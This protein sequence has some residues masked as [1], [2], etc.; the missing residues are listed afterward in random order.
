[1]KKIFVFTFFLISLF[2]YATHIVGGE[3]A[4]AHVSGNQYKISF[5]IFTDAIN[6]NPGAIDNVAEI[7]FFDKATN[8]K[9]DSLSLPLI[10]MDTLPSEDGVCAFVKFKTARVT[11]SSNITLTS[12]KYTGSQ[13][14]YVA[15]DRCCRN[16]GT[17][18][19]V[20]SGAVGTIIYAEF[21]PVTT[22]NSSPVFSV[23][24][25]TVY[26]C[27]GIPQTFSF[28]ATDA[29]GDD[30]VYSL[31]IPLNGNND[32]FSPRGFPK[33]APYANAPIAN[34]FSL[35][36]LI[37]GSPAATVNSTT[38]I[39][40][41]VPTLTGFY[42]IRVKVKEFRN[43]NY[44]GEVNREYQLVI[45]SCYAQNTK[46]DLLFL[47]PQTGK[48]VTT[49]SSNIS[50]DGS[51]AI[52]LTFAGIDTLKYQRLSMKGLSTNFGNTTES[53]DLTPLNHIVKNNKDT[54]FF[55]Y[56][57]PACTY[58]TDSLYKLNFTLKNENNCSFPNYS[59]FSFALK[60]T[61]PLVSPPNINYSIPNNSNVF[62]GETLNM[63]V[64]ITSKN[65]NWI[66]YNT[67]SLSPIPKLRGNGKI[68]VIT[69]TSYPIL[70]SDLNR[71]QFFYTIRATDSTCVNKSISS[72]SITLFIQKKD[73]YPD[74]KIWDAQQARFSSTIQT[75]NFEK[76]KPFCLT[77]AGIE[78]T[79]GQN[80]S[81]DASA[82]N[83]SS[84]LNSSSAP[85]N[86]TIQFNTDTAKFTYCLATCIPNQ[87]ENYQL[88]FK[89]KSQSSCNVGTSTG[90]TISL[91]NISRSKPDLLVFDKIN[92]FFTTSLPAINFDGRKDLCLSFTGSDI[93]AG[94]KIVLNVAQK[95]NP[96]ITN[97]S[98]NPTS[99]TL[100][101]ANEKADFRFCIPKC[102]QNNNEPISL[103]FS[104]KSS[105]NCFSGTS[106]GINLELKNTVKKDLKPI[107]T[108]NLLDI[109]AVNYYINNSMF[110]DIKA[111]S[112]DSN[113]IKIRTIKSGALPAINAKGFNQSNGSFSYI[114]RCPEHRQS[115]LI[116]KIVAT[117]SSCMAQNSDTLTLNI[118][119]LDSL[120]AKNVFISNVITPNNDDKN[121]FFEIKNLPSNTCDEKFEKL[122][123]Y[124][125]WGTKIY[126]HEDR[127]IKWD[128]SNSPDGI[129][130]YVL[131]YTT[132]V[133]KGWIQVV[134]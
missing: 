103:I 7:T 33:A 109:N 73:T 49:V 3:F 91:N 124:N 21:P 56:C 57:I 111:S 9:L 19:I 15:W 120:F 13:G 44:I 66:N 100:N 12:P 46:P 76:D 72:K 36:N 84:L 64:T 20:N 52:C 74:L 29:D 128:A 112:Q 107:I 127:N 23:P 129:Y 78:T 16:A 97:F 131:S 108:T 122:E 81:L 123:I 54:A 5:Y 48:Y 31:E 8:Q 125:R 90:I 59:N 11:Y 35:S 113:W 2:S 62:V 60:S 80:V 102:F 61:V 45:S 22:V 96:L 38:G 85:T 27:V 77:F 18:N 28:A 68:Q 106:N 70:C 117:D 104:L 26:G 6:G 94:Q 115:P 4:L 39:L 126:K 99:Y 116:Y 25:K 14:F 47:N 82:I 133:Y 110:F 65:G 130:F 101:S 1:M 55:Q 119:V 86:K 93:Y 63:V 34:P 92:S 79:L 41:F 105:G 75:L 95:S 89:L 32:Q 30:L 10:K 17:N 51:Q 50:F 42:G 88:N 58:N 83:F 98:S 69:T 53:Q 43:G 87:S 134:R 121:D 132:E 118:N 24:I 114:F 40:S 71:T 37:P 67:N